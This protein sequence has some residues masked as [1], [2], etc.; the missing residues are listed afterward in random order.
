MVINQSMQKPNL[1]IIGGGIVGL[2]IARQAYLENKFNDIS[3]VEKEQKFAIHSSTR[4]SGVIHAGFYYLSNS[5]KA[6]FC[7]SANKMLRDYCIENNLPVNKCGKVVVTKNTEEE[8]ILLE[9][10]N[11]GNKNGCDIRILPKKELSN[12]EPNA[13]TFSNFLWS[14]NTWSASPI[15]VVENIVKE[16]KEANIKFLFNQKVIGFCKN[17][18][19]LSSGQSI[20]YDFL[21]NAAG[22]Y[23]LNVAEVFGI[24]T[25]YKLLPFKGLYLSTRSNKYKMKSHVYPVPDIEQPFLGIHTTLNYKNQLKIG[26]TAIP[27]FSPENYKLFEGIDFNFLHQIVPLQI[28][29]L[30]KN[31]F[32]FRNHAL[33]EIKF[34]YKQNII[35]EIKKIIDMNLDV[36]DFEW[37][38]PGIRAQL[39]NTK[40]KSLEND[41]VLQED[42]NRFHILNSISPAWTCSL[43]TA[44]YVINHIV[45]NI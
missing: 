36:K 29:L 37:Y 30:L 41:F 13:K 1:V 20:K 2:T 39:Y 21:V 9:L 14:P 25:K 12:F 23:A 8:K 26:P 19:L 34:I 40:E 18:L 17:N 24:K 6:K 35:N 22:G 4:N 31:H 27:A 11:R 3:I 32:K 15:D 44:E 28:E 43:K 10:E 45:K 16:L 42:Q 5:K 38:S 33:R 7:A